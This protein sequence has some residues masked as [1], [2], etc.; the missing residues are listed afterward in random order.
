MRIIFALALVLLFAACHSN[1]DVPTDASPTASGDLVICGEIGEATTPAPPT[2]EPSCNPGEDVAN[3]LRFTTEAT[4]LPLP[5]G[6]MALTNYFEIS[7]GGGRVTM[8]I[9]L[10]VGFGDEPV[11]VVTP[12]P[13]HAASFY[14]YAAGGWQR[15]QAADIVDGNNGPEAHGSFDVAPANLIVLV[16]R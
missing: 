12:P 3:A 11:V 16:E 14:T 10:R 13:G 2:P 6:T 15:L 5:A 8:S 4:P 9:T 1:E 7:S